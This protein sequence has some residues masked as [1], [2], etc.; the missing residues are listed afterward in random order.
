MS[1]VCHKFYFTPS[2]KRRQENA[3]KQTPLFDRFLMERHKIICYPVRMIRN[4]THYP[5]ITLSFG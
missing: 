2:L 5:I 4:D 1:L 3:N